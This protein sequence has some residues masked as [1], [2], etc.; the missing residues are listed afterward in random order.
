LLPRV[1]AWP[2][3]R[4]AGTAAELADTITARDA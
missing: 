2:A 4:S 1:C 3:D